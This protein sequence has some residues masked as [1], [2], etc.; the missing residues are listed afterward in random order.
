MSML[1]NRQTLLLIGDILALLLSFALMVLIRFDTVT[2]HAF[3]VAQAQ[4]FIP[5][6]FV[7]LIIFFVFDLYDVRRVNPNPRNIGLLI[8]AMALSG[9][10]SILVFYISPTTGITPKTN[11]AIIAGIAFVLLVMW[12]RFFYHLFTARIRQ[13]IGIIGTHPLLEDLKTELGRHRQLG[14]VVGHWT[15]ESEVPRNIGRIDL[16]ISEST[17]PQASLVL[18]RNFNAALLSLPQA[19]ETL[20]AK[21]PLELVTNE[22]AVQLMSGD[23]NQG[24]EL[25]Y[26]VLE[27]V[28]AVFV[29]VITS[30]FMLIA[31]IAILIE[32]GSPVVLRQTRVGKHGKLF[33]M[34][35]LRSMKALAPDGSAETSGAQWADKNDTRRTRVGK[36]LVKTHL[37]EVPQMW[38][39]IRGDIAL[40]GPRAE[41]PQFVATLE[42][43][44]PYY[45]LRHTIKPGFTGWAQIKYRYARSIEDSKE[46]FEYDLY[47]LKNKSPLLDIGIV[48]KTLQIIFTH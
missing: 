40:I 30:P 39:I 24:L 32:D 22:R 47:Y 29:L 43:Q 45:Y 34:F 17:D 25:L 14:I 1:K 8:G 48:L 26:R 20:L 15:T 38:N 10:V 18:T 12:R 2:Q 6:F 37:D 27:I 33:T 23:R 7:W 3:I 16:F 11:L 35:K 5:L 9:A 19:Y 42:E 31:S 41:R 36:V 46:K 44:I 28:V 4:L 13:R 21:I